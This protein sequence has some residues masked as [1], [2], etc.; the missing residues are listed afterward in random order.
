MEDNVDFVA[1][2]HKVATKVKEVDPN[3]RIRDIRVVGSVGAGTNKP[4]SDIDVDVILENRPRGVSTEFEVM[5]RLNPQLEGLKHPS[6][7][8]QKNIPKSGLIDI[9]FVSSTNNVHD[10]Y[11]QFSIMPGDSRI[12]S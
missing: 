9:S 10:D 7:L 4:D 5:K 2:G 6:D 11:P 3:L 8:K 1:L 12:D